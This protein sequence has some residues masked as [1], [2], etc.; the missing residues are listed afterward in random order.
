MFQNIYSWML[1]NME[2]LHLCSL[3]PCGRSIWQTKGHFGWP[4]FYISGWNLCSLCWWSWRLRL[5]PFLCR[6]RQGTVINFRQFL[7]INTFMPFEKNWPKKSRKLIKVVIFWVILIFFA[8]SQWNSVTNHVLEWIGLN[9]YDYDG[10]Q[11]KM[12]HTKH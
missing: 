11:P 9:F 6:T 4:L 10:L 12:T 3:W 5:F 7:P 2:C 1:L 8:S